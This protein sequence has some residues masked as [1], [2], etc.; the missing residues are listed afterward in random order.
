MGVRSLD[1]HCADGK[2]SWHE[3]GTVQAFERTGR[4]AA[5]RTRD[6]LDRPLLVEYLSAL[7]IHVDQSNY[8]GSAW[9]VREMVD[10]ETR[11][12]SVRSFRRENSWP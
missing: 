9:V 1:A 10:W 7:E 2:W 6:R 5:R 3:C 11:R 8:F 12:E 4:Y